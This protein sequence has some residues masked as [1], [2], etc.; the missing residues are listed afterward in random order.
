MPDFVQNGF[1]TPEGKRVIEHMESTI[2][3]AESA[4]SIDALN[5]L[6]GPLK[7][8]YLNVMKAKTLSEGEWLRDYSYAAGT[9][10]QALVEADTDKAEKDALK[11]ADAGIAAELE[12]V[13]Q[14][15]ESVV[16]DN[17]ALR[18]ELDELKKPAKKG[19]K[20][21]DDTEE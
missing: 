1:V 20:K 14:L 21:T 17:K 4:D 2:N 6:S 18:S 13:K 19:S 3:V 7:H 11:E 16:T 15:L 9:V 8:Y 10:H 5:S 12:K